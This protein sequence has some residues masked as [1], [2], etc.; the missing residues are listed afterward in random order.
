MLDQDELHMRPY[1]Y[2]MR[3]YKIS[4]NELTLYAAFSRYDV[5]NNKQQLSSSNFSLLL[6]FPDEA[7]NR[8]LCCFR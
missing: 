5:I 1:D 8:G 6:L 2:G 4:V 3:V 7:P